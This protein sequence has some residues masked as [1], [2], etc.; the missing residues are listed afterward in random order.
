MSIKAGFD[1]RALARV[2]AA[3]RADVES[4]I[5][6]GAVIKVARHGQIAL[7]ATIGFQSPS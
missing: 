3:I 7:D 4:G 5:Y 6:D 2:E 1:D